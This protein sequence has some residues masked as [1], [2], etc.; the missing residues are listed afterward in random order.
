MKKITKILALLS[1][2]LLVLGAGMAC[3]DVEIVSPGYYAGDY[4]VTTL[5]P[6][7]EWTDTSPGKASWFKIEFSEFHFGT[8]SPT[9]TKHVR[10][11]AGTTDFSVSYNGPTLSWDTIYAFTVTKK[12]KPRLGIPAVSDFDYFSTSGQVEISFV[13]FTGSEYVRIENYSTTS[14]VQLKNWEL[15]DGYWSYIFPSHT[16]AAGDYVDVHT[17]NGSDDAHNLYWDY[18]RSVWNDD[19]DTA[20]LYNDSHVLVDTYTYY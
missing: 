8:W 20:Y 12:G 2:T 4:Y 7:L 13:A 17:G 18:D 6:T 11:P 19:G 1:V 9:W 5:T 15:T 16:L 10:G 14:D 3:A